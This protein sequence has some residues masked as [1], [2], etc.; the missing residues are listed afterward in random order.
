MP[1]G[2]TSMIHNKISSN[3]KEWKNDQR[4]ILL[5]IFKQRHCKLKKGYSQAINFKLYKALIRPIA[6]YSSPVWSP[7]YKSHI[8]LIERIQRNFTRYAMHYPPLNYKDRCVNMN[9]LPLSF[10]REMADIKLFFKSMYTTNFS[11]N[12]S[13]LVKTFI[14]NSRLRSHQKGLL[15]ES[16]LV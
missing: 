8:E 12:I 3:F 5:R 6:E 11:N 15:L 14:P 2:L 10:R 7:F 4:N 16:K 1:N 13:E 9:I